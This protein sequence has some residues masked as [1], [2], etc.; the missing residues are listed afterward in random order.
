MNV[1][2]TLF[3][4]CLWQSHTTEGEREE[5]RGGASSARSQSHVSQFE[6]DP[7]GGGGGGSLSAGAE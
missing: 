3:L 1:C 7:G 4:F 6:R 5:V 2:F